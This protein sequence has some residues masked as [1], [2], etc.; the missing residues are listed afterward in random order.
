MAPEQES[1][2]R[3]GSEEAGQTPRVHRRGRRPGRGRRG[4]GRRPAG[5]GNE[6]ST[7]A[8][9]AP[10]TAEVLREEQSVASDVKPESIAE[11]TEQATSAPKPFPAK[12]VQEAIEEVTHIIA[13]LRE[14]LDEMEE[15]LETLELAER[16]KDADEREIESLRNALRNLQRSRDGQRRSD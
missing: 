1:D 2:L 5:Q 15:V 3:P 11:R 16:Q 14:A 6:P 4:R 9:P 12:A 7:A 10:V 8:A 13:N